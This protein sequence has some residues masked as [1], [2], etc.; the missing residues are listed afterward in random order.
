MRRDFRKNKLF[1]RRTFLLSGVQASLTTIL[2]TR[3]AY[4]QLIKYDEYSTKSDS[5]RIKPL[6]N[7]A[8]RGVIVDRNGFPMTRNDQNYRLLLYSENRSN[9]ANTI[10][11]VAK[12]LYLDQQTKDL[13]FK[14]L[15]I[16]AE[17]A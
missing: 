2:I 14:R 16:S 11:S 8:P 3:L 4:L 1:N 15:K 13:I 5:N 10:E 12:I 17:K 6:I 7:P 9:I